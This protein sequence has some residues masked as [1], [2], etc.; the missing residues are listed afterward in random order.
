MAP[1]DWREVVLREKIYRGGRRGD[2]EM[3]WSVILG[4]Y[5]VAAAIDA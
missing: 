4:K 1:L 2:S 3:C 5:G